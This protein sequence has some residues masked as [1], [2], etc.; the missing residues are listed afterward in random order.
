MNRLSFIVCLVLA[1]TANA[2]VPS[3]QPQ[4]QR[5]RLI[6]GSTAFRPQA[7]FMSK[8][9]SNSEAPVSKAPQGNFYDDEVGV[10]S[11]M[12]YVNHVLYHSRS[13]VPNMSTGQPRL[14]RT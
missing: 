4:F 12:E 7:R 11:Q 1:A 2:F 9:D 10:S 5:A 3:T 13:W 8:D 6:S 14:V